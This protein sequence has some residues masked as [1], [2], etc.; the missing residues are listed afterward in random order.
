M[1]GLIASYESGRGIRGHT[2]LIKLL[3]SPEKIKSTV[4][5]SLFRDPMQEAEASSQQE[6]IDPQKPAP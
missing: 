2:K 1:Q 4:E 3:Y 5:R 6:T